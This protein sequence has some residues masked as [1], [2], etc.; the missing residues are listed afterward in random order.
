GLL[1]VGVGSLPGVGEDI[2]AWM[3]YD[4]AKKVSREPEAFG[5]GSLEGVVAAETANNACIGGALIPLLTLGIPGSPPAMMLLS[6]LKLNDVPVGPLLAETTPTF[7]PQMAAILLWAS[8]AMLLAGF[9]FTRV[10]V[11]VLRIPKGFLMP[12]VAVFTVIGAYAFRNSLWDVYLM[13]GFGAV[14]YL[15]EEGGFPVAPLVIG[16]ILGPM[17]E[18]NLRRMLIDHGNLLP[19]FTRPVSLLFIVL[20]GVSLAWQWLKRG[21]SS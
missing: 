10:S 20:I 3:S 2:A 21:R 12:L 11:N 6:A 4:T 16:I 15:M 1:G 17:A 7:I 9:L 5:K 18:E 19:V 13:L 8:L 14:A